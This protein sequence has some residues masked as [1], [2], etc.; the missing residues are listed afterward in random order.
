MDYEAHD[1]QHRA[2]S[3]H[4]KPNL[5]RARQRDPVGCNLNK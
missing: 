4:C 5:D 1:I 2:T 3:L